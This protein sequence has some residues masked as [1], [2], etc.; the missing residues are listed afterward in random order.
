MFLANGS[1]DLKMACYLDF[2]YITH[3][4]YSY[5]VAIAYSRSN[6]L[7]P[8]SF[9]LLSAIFPADA[10]FGV[11]PT[12]FVASAQRPALGGNLSTTR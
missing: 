1:L 2:I 8:K 11:R 3:N 6:T 9:L 10:F 4:K 12:P 7:L 5:Y